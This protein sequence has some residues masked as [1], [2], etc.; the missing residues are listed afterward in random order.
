MCEVETHADNADLCQGQYIDNS[1]TRWNN[2][3]CCL[4]KCPSALKDPLEY[5][6]HEGHVL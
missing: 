5:Q 1:N 2:R 3:G 6:G 4:I